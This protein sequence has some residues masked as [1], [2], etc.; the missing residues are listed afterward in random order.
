M[1][2]NREFGLLLVIFLTGCSFVGVGRLATA[3]TQLTVEHERDLLFADGTTLRGRVISRLQEAQQVR[4]TPEEALLRRRI[5]NAEKTWSAL[6]E[7]F[8]AYDSRVSDFLQRLAT[9]QNIQTPQGVQPINLNTQLQFAI[10]ASQVSA[11]REA[12]R[13]ALRDFGEL[14]S[15]RRAQANTVVGLMV[16]VAAIFISLFLGIMNFMSR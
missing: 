14:I 3:A 12:I 4:V 5:A 2:H 9:A 1:E 7:E 10:Y 8:L 13:S 16:S 11:H 15:S 6:T